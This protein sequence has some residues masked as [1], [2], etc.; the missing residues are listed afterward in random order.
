MLFRSNVNRYAHPA[1]TL[2]GNAAIGHLDPVEE[3]EAMVKTVTATPAPVV[4]RVEGIFDDIR[5][6][7][8]K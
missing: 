5:S 6:G 1:A 8:R 7:K 4:K 3:L 2:H